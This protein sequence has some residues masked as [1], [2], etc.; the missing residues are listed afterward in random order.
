V[1]A[2]IQG[3][4][5]SRR[6]AELQ[7]HDVEEIGKDEDA[8]GEVMAGADGVAVKQDAHLEGLKLIPNPPDLEAWRQRLF[9]VDGLVGLSEEE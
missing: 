8:G 4:P 6:I 2:R 5:A 1:S 9:G 7:Q 3:I